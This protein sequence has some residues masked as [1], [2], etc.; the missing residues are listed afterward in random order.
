MAIVGIGHELRG[1][2]AA[3]PEIVRAL[4]ARLAGR[5]FIALIDAGPA[6]ENVTGAIRKHQPV[7]TLLVDAA[8][9]SEPPGT[10]RW[11][12]W[13]DTDG[14]SAAGHTLPLS[15]LAGYL[16]AELGC[17]VGLLG[18]QPASA[19][20]GAPLSPAVQAAVDEIVEALTGLIG[21]A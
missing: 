16:E 9:M 15:V 1:D 11:L 17:E 2:D 21:E 3:G 19:E 12:D 6:P 7:F 13:R 4:Q 18:I 8:E 14:F 20:F 10:V 5:E